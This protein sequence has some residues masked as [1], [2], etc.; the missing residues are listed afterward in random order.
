MLLFAV[1][2]WWMLIAEVCISLGIADAAKTIFFFLMKNLFVNEFKFN[3][4]KKIFF[5]S[6]KPNMPIQWSQL[7]LQEQ[8]FYYTFYILQNFT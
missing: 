3:V 1:V 8:F 7:L 2:S 6:D 5:A 4:E